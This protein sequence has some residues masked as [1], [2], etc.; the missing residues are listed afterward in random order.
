MMA[1]VV[2]PL[3]ADEL[4]DALVL[5]RLGYSQFDEAEWRGELGVD[6]AHAGAGCALIAR[7]ETGRACGLILYRCVEGPGQP[8][9]LEIARL[10][11]F[12]LTD[13]QP[14]ARALLEEAIRCA[15]REGCTALRL[16]LPLDAPSDILALVLASGL[17]DLHSVF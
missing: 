1:F 2:T 5:A 7:N 3:R 11:A 12:D 8:A 9:V 10:I 17:T 4:D 13:P 6:A 14:I 15:V 16:V